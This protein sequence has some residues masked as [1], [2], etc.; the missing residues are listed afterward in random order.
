MKNFQIYKLRSLFLFNLI[1]LV[2]VFELEAQWTEASLSIKRGDVFP[3]TVGNKVYFFGGDPIGNVVDVYDDIT[4]KWKKIN[5][6]FNTRGFLSKPGIVVKKTIFIMPNGEDRS[7]EVYMLDTD[8]DVITQLKLSESRSA[9]GI[10]SIGDFVVFAGGFNSTGLSSVIDLYNRVEKKWIIHNLSTARAFISIGSSGNQIFF[11][12]GVYGNTPSD[13]VDIYN[14]ETQNWTTTKLN[15]ARGMMNTINIGNKLIFAGGGV[16]D[17]IPFNGVD[18][19]DGETN[20]WSH[21]ELKQ[22]TFLNTLQSAV[23]GNKAFF[24]GGTGAS[25][26]KKIIDIYDSQSNTWDTIHGPNPHQLFTMVVLYNRVFFGGGIHTPK[27]DIY[28]IKSNRWVDGGQLTEHRYYI[29]GATVGNKAIFA[30]GQLNSGGYTS[31]VD[32]YTDESTSTSDIDSIQAFIVYPNPFCEDFNIEIKSLEHFQILNLSIYDISG[33]AIYQFEY[34]DIVKRDNKRLFWDG[35]LINGQSIQSGI[36]I[37]VCK[38]KT[39]I[40]YQKVLKI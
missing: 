6:P 15:T 29:A 40:Y 37:I 22:Y 14:I 38:T 3:L 33:K 8:S 2:F 12:G 17:F 7:D 39:G 18:I 20:L 13:I 34:E 21:T 1:G 23:S 4:R 35:K 32:I 30:G 5:L 11:A 24:A 26:N 19:Y 27:V 31:K 36:Y 25:S 16:P 28:D 10:G 9:I